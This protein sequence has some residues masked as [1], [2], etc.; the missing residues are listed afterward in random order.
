MLLGAEGRQ[1][2]GRASAKGRLSRAEEMRGLWRA[3]PRQRKEQVQ[4]H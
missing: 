2:E 3:Y 4:R 1:V